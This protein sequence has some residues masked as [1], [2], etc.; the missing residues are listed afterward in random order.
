M[1]LALPETVK[2]DTRFDLGA[3]AAYFTHVLAVEVR[4]IR[5]NSA[6]GRDGSSRRR[7]DVIV[8]QDLRFVGVFLFRRRLGFRRLGGRAFAHMQATLGAFQRLDR[9]GCVFPNGVI[10]LV[11]CVTFAAAF[12]VWLLHGT[13][14]AA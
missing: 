2:V 3:A 5:R 8:L 14:P 6:R 1:R 10:V 9:G 12:A 13:P 7:L 11:G 4:E